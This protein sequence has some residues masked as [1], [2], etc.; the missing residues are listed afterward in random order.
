MNNM[1]TEG[2]EAVLGYL[3]L[4]FLTPPPALLTTTYRNCLCPL[5]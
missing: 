1:I 4:A 5:E 2:A 3:A